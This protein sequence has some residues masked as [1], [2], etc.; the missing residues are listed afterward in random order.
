[1]GQVLLR[2]RGG[3]PVTAPPRRALACLRCGWAWFPRHA[4]TPR[5]CPRCKSPY[6][7]RERTRA[8]TVRGP[9][10]AD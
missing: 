10:T 2:R 4:G 7:A 9:A 1:M 3:P 6:W 5:T 8:A